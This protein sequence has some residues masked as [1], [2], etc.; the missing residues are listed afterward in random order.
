[1][2][3][4]PFFTDFLC[5][6]SKLIIEL[7]GDSHNLTVQEDARRTTYLEQ[8]GYRIIRFMNADVLNNPEGV[9]AIIA[10]NLTDLPT[11][12]PSP[13]RGGR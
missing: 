7:D 3:V 9:L 10:E 2:P 13:A 11:P 4:G 8:A 1:M 12:V 6:R 5:R